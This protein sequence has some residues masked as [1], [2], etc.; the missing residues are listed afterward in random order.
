M[1]FLTAVLCLFVLIGA[2][3]SAHW[4]FR[5]SWG[6]LWKF[7]GCMVILALLG[8]IFDDRAPM[9]G[10]YNPLAGV[11]ASWG[12][13]ISAIWGFKKAGKDLRWQSGIAFLALCLLGVIWIPVILSGMLPHVPVGGLTPSAH[14]S[15]PPSRPT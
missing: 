11:L 4:V 10:L 6:M 9:V 7:G 5:Q 3:A 8:G 15:P 1:A 13:M 2:L 14:A 12:I